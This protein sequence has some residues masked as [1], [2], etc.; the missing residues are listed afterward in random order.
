MERLQSPMRS[1]TSGVCCS[2]PSPAEVSSTEAR[3]NA[4]LWNPRRFRNRRSYMRYFLSTVASSGL[5]SLAHVRR[6]LS[7]DHR[8]SPPP[9]GRFARSDRV[10]GEMGRTLI[11]GGGFGGVSTAVELR[12]IAPGH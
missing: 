7:V 8:D 1:S 12:R 3:T 11:L 10:A 4:L 2:D 5:G 9:H 6:L